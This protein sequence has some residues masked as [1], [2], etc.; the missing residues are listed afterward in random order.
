MFRNLT[1]RN[2]LPSNH[3]DELLLCCVQ[4]VNLDAVW[5]RESATVESTLWVASQ[6]VQDRVGIP[7]SFPFVGPYPLADSFGFVVAIGMV[8]KSLEPGR[9]GKHQQFES[10][11]K[12]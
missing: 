10:I 11:H 9:Y 4:R 1:H 8:L 12:L 6:L 5:G 2:L 3:Q 7:P